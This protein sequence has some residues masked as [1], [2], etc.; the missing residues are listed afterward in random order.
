MFTDS[1]LSG[2]WGEHL[3]AA[4][5]YKRGCVGVTWPDVDRGIDLHAKFPSVGW[6][7]VQVKVVRESSTSGRV[8]KERIERCMKSGA[9]IAILV[10]SQTGGIRV[11]DLGKGMF[12]EEL[13][14]DL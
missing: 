4:H 6:V 2:A 8:F 10:G 13:R 9:D 7:T 14:G 5:C 12:P 1:L 3:G 11:L